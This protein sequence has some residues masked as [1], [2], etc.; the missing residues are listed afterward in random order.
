MKILIIGSGYVGLVTG[1][2]LSE[3]GHQV[4]CY[5]KDFLKVKKISSGDQLF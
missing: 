5:E 2:C 4:L 3:K 1:V